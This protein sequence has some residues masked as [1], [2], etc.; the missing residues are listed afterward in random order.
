MSVSRVRLPCLVII[1]AA[2]RAAAAAPSR[3]AGEYAEDLSALSQ[4]AREIERTSGPYSYAVRTTASY[5]CLSYG[6]DGELKRSRTTARASGTAFVSRADSNRTAE[7]KRSLSRTLGAQRD[8][9]QVLL[10][11]VS[12]ERSRASGPTIGIVDIENGSPSLSSAISTSP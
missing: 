4:H 8:A 9:A 6:R 11:L 1:A 7:Q 3:C 5:E 10:E 12:R 2:A